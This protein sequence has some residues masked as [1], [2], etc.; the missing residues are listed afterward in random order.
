MLINNFSQIDLKKSLII[1]FEIILFNK[2][3]IYETLEIINKLIL[4]I[5]DFIKL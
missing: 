3:I 5:K 2:I 1:I 4:I